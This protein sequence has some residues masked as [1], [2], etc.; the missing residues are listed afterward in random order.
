MTATE[1]FNQLKTD[2]DKTLTAIFNVR[3]T[4]EMRSDR[5]LPGYIYNQEKHL[6]EYW[7]ALGEYSFT[8]NLVRLAFI[9][10]DR[11]LLL[12]DLLPNSLQSRKDT[13]NFFQ[14]FKSNKSNVVASL[15]RIIGKPNVQ[16]RTYAEPIPMEEFLKTVVSDIHDEALNLEYNYN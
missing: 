12:P 16:L 1:A 4:E 15:D 5:N 7:I 8:G 14:L 11:Q 2:I 6:H 9:I 13:F 3:T 10:N